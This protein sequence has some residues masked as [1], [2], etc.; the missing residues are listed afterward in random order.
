MK[1]H[2]FFYGICFVMASINRTTNQIIMKR[3][4]LFSLLLSFTA[5]AFTQDINNLPFI[6]VTGIAEK[7]IIP[8]EIYISIALEERYDG[9]KNITL[10][11]QEKSLKKGLL[12][13]GIDLSQLSLSNANSDYIHVKWRKKDAINRAEYQ[14]LVTDAEAVGKVF[15]KLDELDIQ[16]AHIAKVDH[17]NIENIKRETR[18][19]AIK[20]AKEKAND[21]LTAIGEST[22]QALLVRENNFDYRPMI[23]RNLN[24]NQEAGLSYA[25]VGPAP[26]EF[27][28]LKIN[29]SVFV[30]FAI[31]Q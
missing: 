29:A 16:N 8:N 28:K 25:K 30:K 9:K 20:D 26:I 5:P 14:I 23:T 10:E 11:E 2:S 22:G 1:I 13:I 27:Q 6:E 24:Y 12:E 3:L 17:S 18:I 19:I 7:E 4:I 21:L 15:Q 31:K